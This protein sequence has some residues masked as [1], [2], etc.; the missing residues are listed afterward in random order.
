MKPDVLP[1]TPKQSNKSSKWIGETSPRLKKLEFQRF[2]IKTTLIYIFY[3]Q[4]IVHKE[5]VPEGKPV[6]A[7]FYK[8]V[9]DGL[10]KVIQLH[11]A[12][13]IFSCCIIMCPPT[14]L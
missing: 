13:E 2:C 11:S 3:S 10:L 1:M 12:L 9:M 7:E 14:K 4:G 6:Y 5:F 8:A